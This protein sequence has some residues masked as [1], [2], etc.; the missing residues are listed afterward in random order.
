MNIEEITIELDKFIKY[1]NIPFDRG[2]HGY[3]DIE[4]FEVKKI[5][6]LEDIQNLDVKEYNIGFLNKVKEFKEVLESYKNMEEWVLDDR[7]IVPRKTLW[8]FDD[9]KFAYK[10]DPKKMDK[11]IQRVDEQIELISSNINFGKQQPIEETVKKETIMERYRREMSE[12]DDKLSKTKTLVFELFQNKDNVTY[13]T[14]N[15]KNNS[16][17]ERKNEI[18]ELIKLEGEVLKKLLEVLNKNEEGRILLPQLRNQSQEKTIKEGDY[19]SK[20]LHP[21]PRL[22]AKKIYSEVEVKVEDTNLSTTKQIVGKDN[23]R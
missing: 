18:V 23:N 10:Q 20:Q 11:L 5:D 15:E 14:H 3:E 19:L 6:L 7:S 13:F 9:Y 4:E 12:K 16:I 22:R 21:T 8:A 17:H 2:F 1:E